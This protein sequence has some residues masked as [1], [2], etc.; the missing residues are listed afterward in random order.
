MVLEGVSAGLCF[1]SVESMS[2]LKNERDVGRLRIG[3]C[4]AN[5]L[6]TFNRFCDLHKLEEEHCLR[7]VLRKPFLVG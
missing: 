1:V 3:T 4:L 6:D 5:G 2:P 7:E